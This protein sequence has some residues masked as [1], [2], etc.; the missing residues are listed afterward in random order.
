M[1]KVYLLNEEFLT[2]LAGEI[3]SEYTLSLLFF[4]SSLS[5]EGSDIILA[6]ILCSSTDGLAQFV[7]LM[8][9]DGT[10]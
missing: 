10:A 5:G 4:D 1:V 8:S 9:V 3:T 2:S 7:L 6:E